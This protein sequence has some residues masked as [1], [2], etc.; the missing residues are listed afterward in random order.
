MAE[1]F[2]IH[3]V[4]ADG[5]KATKIHVSDSEKVDQD[6]AELVEKHQGDIGKKM[7][8]VLTET[9]YRG[10]AELRTYTIGPKRKAEKKSAE[11]EG[12][13]KESIEKE[14]TERLGSVQT[15]KV[16]KTNTRRKSTRY[17]LR[18]RKASRKQ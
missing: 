1:N 3:A 16:K 5:L 8:A 10:G 2:G 18:P 13:E 14:G 15:G 9:V 11:K 17:N 6:V 4:Y 7:E 12:T